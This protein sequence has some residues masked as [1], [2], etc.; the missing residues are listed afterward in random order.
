MSDIEPSKMES[1]NKKLDDILVDFFESLG[2]LYKE[3]ANLENLMKNGFLMM[4][5]ARYNM[6]AKSVSVSQYDESSMKASKVVMVTKEDHNKTFQLVNP[7]NFPVDD[8]EE[9]TT[10]T[11]LRQRKG[12]GIDKIET[13]GST[14]IENSNDS[15]CNCDPIKWFG[16]LVPQSL[17]QSQGYFQQAT[18]AAVSV[19][20]LKS[21]VLNLKEQYK[22]V[23]KEKQTTST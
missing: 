20:N 13:L 22:E 15:K 6:G 12:G 17:R 16:V 14:V 18:D 3:Q 7:S 11:G 4:S 8:S 21:K 1:L 9:I 23:M 19:S 5:R 2:E 10:S